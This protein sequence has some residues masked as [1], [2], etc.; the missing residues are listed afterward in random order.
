MENF[1]VI[2]S[3]ITVKST[4]DFLSDDKFGTLPVV[5]WGL[6]VFSDF[7]KLSSVEATPFG[8]WKR[9]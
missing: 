9:N 8:I 3:K 7:T 1:V 5:F 4:R 2:W 6:G